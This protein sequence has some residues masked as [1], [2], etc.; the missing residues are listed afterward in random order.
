MTQ[1]QT[2]LETTR[3]QIFKRRLSSILTN[4][5][6]LFWRVII[7]KYTPDIILTDLNGAVIKG[8]DFSPLL[9]ELFSLVFERFYPYAA[10]ST[11][12][13][14]FMPVIILTDAGVYALITNLKISA[15][16]DKTGL[17][18]TIQ[19]YSTKHLPF[20]TRPIFAIAINWFYKPRLEGGE[21]CSVIQIWRS[22]L[23]SYQPISSTNTICK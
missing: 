15:S 9:N 23:T 3:R 10:T 2:L 6:H 8:S 18:K 14:A 5:L 20:I 11:R 19:K 13:N 22:H 4:N 21:G 16:A 7:P 17:N 1:Y 12:T